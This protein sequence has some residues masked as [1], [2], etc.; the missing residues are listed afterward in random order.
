MSKLKEL[1]NVATEVELP[2]SDDDSVMIFEDVSFRE[3]KLK[4]LNS[5]KNNSVYEE[6]TDTGQKCISTRWICSLKDT[7]EGTIHKARLVAR[8]FEEFNRDD[9]PKDSPT[10]GTDSLRLVLAI[11]AQRS[12]KTRTMDIKTA[13]FTRS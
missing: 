2:S 13:F 7:S 11:L 10:C 5:W 9:I 1:E 8:G 4:E 12:W 6:C 3:A